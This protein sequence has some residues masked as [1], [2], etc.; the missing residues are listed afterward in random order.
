MLRSYTCRN[1]RLVLVEAS[2]PDQ[3]GEP[4]VWFDLLNPTPEEDHLVEERLGIAV[5]TRDEMEEIELS[6]R[7]YHEGDAE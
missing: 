6:A 1:D 3:G 5:P 7:L 2:S 4:A